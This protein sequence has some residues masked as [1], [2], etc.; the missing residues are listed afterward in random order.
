MVIDTSA[1]MAVLLD[2][3]LRPAIEAA[4]NSEPCCISAVTVVELLIVAEARAGVEGARIV[5]SLLDR[6][7]V[8]VIA[9]DAPQARE[10]INGWR[11]FGKGR[12]RAGLN[13]GDCFA[14]AA[15]ID[16]SEP[17]LFVGSDFSQ[18]DVVSAMT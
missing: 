6:F 7:S 9:V 11:R 4:L 5:E 1:V 2:E 14:Y 16:R 3:P 13:L 17:L 15:A 10:A 18:T 12:H 8:E